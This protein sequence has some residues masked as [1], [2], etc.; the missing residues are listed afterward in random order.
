[1]IQVP[2]GVHVDVPLQVLFL[3]SVGSS[4]TAS[5]PRLL[6][7]VG[8]GATLHLKQSYASVTIDG[9]G[10]E[11]ES[12]IVI[13]EVTGLDNVNEGGA[14]MTVEVE[15]KKSVPTLVTANTRI[16][17]GRGGS[18]MKH[19]YTQESAGERHITFFHPIAVPLLNLLT[20]HNLS[21]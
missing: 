14:S 5:Y 18:K 3:S 13:D 16:V 4:P 7:S 20:S 12:L 6:V 21:E 2:A 8:D 19:T 10:L 15:D 11:E 17:L 1:V 9:S